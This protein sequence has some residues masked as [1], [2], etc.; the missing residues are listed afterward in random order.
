MK[1]QK[2]INI[3]CMLIELTIIATKVSRRKFEFTRYNQNGILR[4]S[5][6]VK[7]D[8]IATVC[9]GYSSYLMITSFMKTTTA[10]QK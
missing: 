6:L 10:V 2:E 4:F 9:S 5:L 8:D 1:S 3:N 7:Q